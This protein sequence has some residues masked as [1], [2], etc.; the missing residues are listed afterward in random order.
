MI[1]SNWDKLFSKI[2]FESSWFSY[3]SYFYMMISACI[4]SS[5]LKSSSD[6]FSLSLNYFID[7]NSS[8]LS[9]T[10]SSNLFWASTFCTMFWYWFLF[11][12]GFLKSLVPKTAVFTGYSLPKFSR[13][14]MSFKSLE[15]IGWKLLSR[16]VLPSISVW[17][18]SNILDSI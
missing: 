14:F 1:S 5:N 11:Y 6:W 12:S 4:S 15:E 17:M 9:R 3:C 8:S 10:C 18:I 2:T 13:S 16:P 7:L